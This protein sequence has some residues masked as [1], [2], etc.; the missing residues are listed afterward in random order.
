MALKIDYV[1]GG[2]M[3]AQTANTVNI[4]KMCAAFAGLGHDVRLLL[5]SGRANLDGEEI[6]EYYDLAA[7]FCVERL[8]VMA[9]RAG[10]L[11]LLAAIK[12]RARRADLVYTRSPRAAHLAARFGLP[13]GLEIHSPV[14]GLHERPAV[15]ALIRSKCLRGLI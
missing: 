6:A 3:P 1:H 15:E 8:G 14:V 2:A 9:K 10:F 12:G 11:A 5:P 7:P 4:A 13:T